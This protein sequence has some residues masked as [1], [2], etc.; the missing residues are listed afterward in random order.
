MVP[1]LKLLLFTSAIAIYYYYSPQ[2][3]NDV[4]VDCVFRR[5]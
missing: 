2:R 5:R 1:R 4:F 3:L